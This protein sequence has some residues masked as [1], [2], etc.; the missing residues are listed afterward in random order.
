MWPKLISERRCK[1]QEQPLS[2]A[3]HGPSSVEDPLDTSQ[4]APNAGPHPRIFL[5]FKG[6]RWA[7]LG[8]L[9]RV[10]ELSIVS[11]SVEV[12]VRTLVSQLAVVTSAASS[13]LLAVVCFL[14]AFLPFFLSLRTSSI[15]LS[16]GCIVNL[17][18]SICCHICKL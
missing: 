6:W 10:C 13:S 18:L 15:R 3:Q 8:A 1:M 11:L 16:S 7:V 5:P 14:F 9:R 2:V 12:A 17:C 4:P